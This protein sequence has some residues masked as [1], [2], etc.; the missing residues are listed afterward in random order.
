[1]LRKPTTQKKIKEISA[2]LEEHY[3]FLYQSVGGPRVKKILRDIVF[4]KRAYR[5]ANSK[6]FG[7]N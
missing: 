4:K 6:N 5:K 2:Y 1:M 7:F 3:P